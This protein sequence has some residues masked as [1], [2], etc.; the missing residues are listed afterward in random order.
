MKTEF[1]E[2][3]FGYAA[4]R[5]AESA[6]A[7]VYKQAGAP[8]LPSLLMEEKYGWD[9]NLPMVEYALFLQFKRP[10][11]VSRRHAKS[12]SWSYVGDRHY[13]FA[14]DTGELQHRRLLELES[15]CASKGRR[16]DVYY[17]APL[18]HR[19]PDFDSAYLNGLVLDQSVI[20]SPSEFGSDGQVHHHATNAVTRAVYVLS[21]PRPPTQQIE[22]ADVKHRVESLVVQRDS[23]SRRLELAELEQVLLALVPESLRTRRRDD[24]API[25]RRIDRLATILGCGLVLFGWRETD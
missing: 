15:E 12:P 25:A 19:Q 5:E 22:W 24:G 17:V 3:S 13:R 14:I 7:A 8:V 6:L 4:I 16:A 20:V 21:D 9:A 10:V 11:F 18:F 1:S 23:G 2:F